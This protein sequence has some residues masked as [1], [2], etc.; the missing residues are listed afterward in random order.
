MT[1]PN[2][3]KRVLI[4]NDN[5]KRDL[6]GLRLLELALNRR[7]VET[8]F[9]APRLAKGQAL[10]F[11]P[12]ALVAARG[13][14]DSARNFAKCCRVYVLPG[15]G[16]MLTKETMLSVFMGRGYWKLDDCSWLARCYLWNENTREWLL[17]SSLFTEEQLKVVGT[18]KLDIYRDADLMARLRQKGKRPFT[19]GVA[20]SAKTTSTYYGH[21]HFAKN[22]FDM[23]RDASFPITVEGGHLEDVIWRDHVILRRMMRNLK[24]YLETFDGPVV[25]RPSPFEDPREYSFL[26]KAFPGRVKV[27]PDQTLPEFLCSVDCLLTCWSTVAIE[28]LLLDIPVVSIAGTVGPRLFEHIDSHT[29]GFDSYV[30]FYHQPESEDALFDMLARARRGA[31][32]PSARPEGDV[33]NLLHSIYNWSAGIVASEQIADD[34]IADITRHE[35]DPYADFGEVFPLRVPLPTKVALPLYH[36]L[37]LFEYFRSGAFSSY[38]SFFSNRHRGIEKLINMS[39]FAR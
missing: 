39:R 15:E 23:H 14:M 20:F 25:F 6:L 24:R 4:Y 18:P 33:R 12:H 1:P 17:D 26:E 7:G 28:A 11:R 10:D 31:L 5:A 35:H 22:Y 21:P 29:S 2:G 13:D 38:R 36:A 30:S 37:A 16:G 19:L 3:P 27:L 34:I 9:C 32:P 8:R